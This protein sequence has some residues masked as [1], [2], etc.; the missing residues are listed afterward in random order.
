MSEPQAHPI[1]QAHTDRIDLFAV[2]LAMVRDLVPPALDAE[3]AA[4]VLAERERSPGLQRS[5]EGGWHS[6]ADLPARGVPA[7]DRLFQA[8]V[9]QLQQLQAS[10][11]RGPD[12]R[13]R[14]AL[15]AW[16]TVM[17]RG[18]YVSVH[19]HADAH[20]S[21]IYYVDAG[22]GEGPASGRISWINPIGP[23]RA[24][25]GVDLVPATFACTPRSGLLV[26][27]PG[28]LRHAVEPYRGSRPRIAIAANLEIRAP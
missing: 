19:D 6:L 8:V 13:A 2:P 25:P 7:L 26:L 9:E 23:A 20:W 27:F 18:D 28:W 1:R 21:A 5:N 3:L 24:M 4:W 10:L 16:A 11:G 14:F 17:E 22:D 15:Q 12:Y